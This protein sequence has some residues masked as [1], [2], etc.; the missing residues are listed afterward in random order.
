[1]KRLLYLKTSCI[2]KISRLFN[3]LLV[4]VGRMRIPSEVVGRIDMG[5]L[6]GEVLR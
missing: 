6:I 4:V 2:G 3:C 1:M 5:G